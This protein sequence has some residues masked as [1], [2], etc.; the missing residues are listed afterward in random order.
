MKFGFV[1]CVQLGLSCME[2]IYEAGG[3]LNLCIS[4]KDDVARKKSGR[5]YIDD[6]CNKNGIELIKVCHIND[7]ETINALKFHEI[8]W[9]FVIGWSQIACTEVIALPKKGTLGIH[10]TLL[11]EGRGR[12]AIPWAILKRLNKTGVTMFKLD[13]G[14]DTG[15]ILSQMEIPL[16]NNIDASKL[17]E[18]VNKAH[19]ELIHRTISSLMSG[20]ILLTEQDSNKATIWPGRRPEDG[21]IDL[22]GSVW[23][24]E[25]LVRAVTRPYPGA[26]VDTG[27]EQ[28][29]IWKA[30]VVPGLT[31]LRCFEFKDGF[32]ECL[33]CSS[34][35]RVAD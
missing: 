10:P 11:P 19:I 33:E 12:A 9:L 14:V 29:V 16:T 20:N 32:L 18:M 13:A 3:K 28:V 31:P 2:A 17:Y 7:L 24:A 23:D 26:F 22:N 34:S 35:D 8:D 5:V 27:D 30:R 21:R 4:L 1:T 15:P 6:F 25:C